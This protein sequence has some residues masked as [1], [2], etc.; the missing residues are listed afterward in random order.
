MLRGAKR[1]GEKRQVWS[2]V[3]GAKRHGEKSK[4]PQWKTRC[5][6]LRRKAE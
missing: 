3:R 5:E 2:T 6:A 1:R 4:G